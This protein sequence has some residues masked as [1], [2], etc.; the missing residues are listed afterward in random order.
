MRQ[1]FEFE[2]YKTSY[3]TEAI[4]GLT[5]F[6]SM[7]YILFVNPQVLGAAHMDPGAVFT[8]TALVTAFG[9]LLMGILAKYP[10]AISPGM[11]INAYFAYSVVIGLGIPW[12][13]ALA[14]VTIAGAIFVVITL[15][16]IRDTILNAIPEDIKYA[17]ASGIGLLIAFIGLKNAQIIVANKDTFVALGD[18]TNGKVLLAILGTVITMA[19]LVRNIRGGIFYGMAI[20]AVIG[21][22]FKLIPL[23]HGVI[24]LPPSLAP[25]FGQAI[26]HIGD[27]QTGHLVIV[28]LTFLLVGFFDTAG[29]IMAVAHQAGLIRHNQLPRAGRALFAT[30]TSFVVGGVLG[31]SPTSAYIESTAGVAAGGRTGFS[32]VVTALLF[33]LALFFS[34]LLSIVTSEVTAP[35]LIV[36]GVLMA[37]AMGKIH[38]NQL[39]IAIPAFV[40]IL[41]MPLTYSI[42]NGIALGFV[43]YPV[44]MTVRGKFKE[45]HPMMLVLFVI[46]LLFLPFLS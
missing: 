35:A 16:K 36:V 6:L 46:F 26:T 39:E 43:L 44:L 1:Y 28:V 41:T 3:A 27:I 7:V 25:T 9:T 34:P 17:T 33:V 19:L 23:P 45:L 13:T 40:V 20:T 2:K 11:G 22:I 12:Q 37:S 14:G 24:S 30:S 42:T 21:M 15:F 31:T 38:W 29:T 32:S 4:A 10:I 8:A 5:T 18:L